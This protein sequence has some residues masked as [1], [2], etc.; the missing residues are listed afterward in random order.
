MSDTYEG[1]CIGGPLDGQMYKSE[2]PDFEVV[3]PLPFAI[4]TPV[5]DPNPPVFQDVFHYRWHRVTG[6]RAVFACGESVESALERVF[7]AYAGLRT[8]DT[9]GR[10][11]RRA[12][13][14]THYTDARKSLGQL[15]R[16]TAKAL[17]EA[18]DK[19]LSVSDTKFTRAP[20][21][22]A[23]D[24]LKALVTGYVFAL[25]KAEKHLTRTPDDR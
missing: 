24:I 9:E 3:N 10:N 5:D 7:E 25:S 21:A 11:P 23:E 16:D 2:R 13:V 19:L 17:Y 15:S 1:I 8:I 6:K 22:V 12:R 18:A 14:F 4:Y 20:S